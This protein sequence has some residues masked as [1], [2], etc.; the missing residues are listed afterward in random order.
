MTVL[1]GTLTL[2]LALSATAQR[3][4]GIDVSHWQGTINWTSVA[5]SGVSFAWCKAAAPC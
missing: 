2:G 3:P 5:T 4:L 1:A